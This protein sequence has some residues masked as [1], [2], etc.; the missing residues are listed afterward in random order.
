MKMMIEGPSLIPVGVGG[1]LQFLVLQI[2]VE[3][4]Y[5]GSP[6]LVDSRMEYLLAFQFWYWEH[7]VENLWGG[8]RKHYFGNVSRWGLARLI[9]Y[10][11]LHQSCTYS[12]PTLH[13]YSTFNLRHIWIKSNICTTSLFAEIVNVLRPLVIFVEELHQVSLTG[14][15]T[16]FQMAH[17]PVTYYS[18]KKV[19]GE[20]FHYCSYTR[21]TW[22]PLTSNSLDL[23]QLEGKLI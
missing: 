7:W 15:L 23:N 1:K 19:W 17:C 22:T 4:S 6:S 13:I 8:E 3:D 12:L 2:L 21:E 5:T 20:A 16:V 18:L 14:C 11:S 9:L 10:T